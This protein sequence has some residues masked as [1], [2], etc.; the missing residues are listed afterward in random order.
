M[1][2]KTRLGKSR[3]DDVYNVW[4]TNEPVLPKASSNGTKTSTKNKL[5]LTWRELKLAKNT[6]KVSPVMEKSPGGT[7][8]Y[9]H[10]SLPMFTVFSWVR[11]PLGRKCWP[12]EGSCL[13]LA[14]IVPDQSRLPQQSCS[15]PEVLGTLCAALDL[16]WSRTTHGIF[17]PT[18]CRF[19]FS[20]WSVKP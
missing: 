1:M 8:T 10:K 6:L 3:R 15:W 20:R 19:P 7:V 9:H 5:L 12:W 4:K 17:P 18:T 13:L 2:Q 11:K 14:C 16:A